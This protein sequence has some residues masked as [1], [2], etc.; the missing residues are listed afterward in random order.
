[1]YG[2]VRALSLSKGERHMYGLVRALSLSKGER[3]MYGLVRA[4]SLSKGCLKC[5]STG[6][7]HVKGGSALRQAQGT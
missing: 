1:M 3:H 4:L 6:S 2:L 7:G 5:P